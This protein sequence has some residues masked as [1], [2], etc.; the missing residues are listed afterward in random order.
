[1]RRNVE[2]ALRWRDMARR[3]MPWLDTPDYVLSTSGG[4]LLC[5][6]EPYMECALMCGVFVFRDGKYFKHFSSFGEYDTSKMQR[7][8]DYAGERGWL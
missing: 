8:V 5:V 3:E 2:A 7:L 1:M 4:E 6:S